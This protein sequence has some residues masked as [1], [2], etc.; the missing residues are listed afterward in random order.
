MH[1]LRVRVVGFGPLD[2]LSFSFADDA[3]AARKLALVV[4]AGAVGKTSLL[5]AIASTRPA[6]AVALPRTRAGA[7][8]A[9][10]DYALGDDDPP[11]PHALRV[12]SPNASI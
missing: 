10:A 8:F 6:H 3:G 4:G 9:V 11:R 2:D 12:A 7:P 1:L 5:A